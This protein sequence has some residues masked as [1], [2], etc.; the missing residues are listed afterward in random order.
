[1]ADHKSFQDGSDFR[2]PPLWGHPYHHS[3]EWLVQ[4]YG[5]CVTQ[6]RSDSS[7]MSGH[8]V[9]MIEEGI[10]SNMRPHDTKRKKTYI[11][12][13]VAQDLTINFYHHEQ[14]TFSVKSVLNAEQLRPKHTTMDY[15]SILTFLYSQL[16]VTPK[17]PEQS[18]K[19]QVYIVTGANTGLGFEAARHLVR[20]GA[21]KVILAC[22]NLEKGEAA[23]KDIEESTKRIGVAE[24]WSL[25]LS[26]FES[27]KEFAKKVDTL[28][29]IDA[30][31]EN[32]GMSYCSTE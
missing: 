14:L 7:L 31:V 27:V 1:M 10:R 17:Y 21:D 4:R 20:L 25:D 9:S 16:F 13:T 5:G 12:N 3:I 22:R 6:I 32:A 18:C 8:P 15:M 23:V 28:P 29:R 19:G 24:V 2:R 30:I 11:R 26:S